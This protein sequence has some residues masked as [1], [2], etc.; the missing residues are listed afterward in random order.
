MDLKDKNNL[1]LEAI[2]TNWGLTR[3]GDVHNIVWEIYYDMTYKVTKYVSEL[4]PEDRDELPY[5]RCY[6]TKGKMKTA[7]FDNLKMLA[8]KKPW[9]TKDEIRACDGTAWDIKLYA[10]DG[11]LLNSSGKTYYIYGEEVLEN[12]VG[13][14]PSRSFDNPK[15]DKDNKEC[16]TLSYFEYTMRFRD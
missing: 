7:H 1:M 15:N 12:I 10:E 13:A 11:L 4:N 5:I 16:Y 8:N 3:A 9:R 2:A 6:V 14:L